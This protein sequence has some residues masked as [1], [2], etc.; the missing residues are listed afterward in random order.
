M[1]ILVP[2]WSPAGP[3]LNLDYLFFSKPMGPSHITKRKK[4]GKKIMIKHVSIEPIF[5]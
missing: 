2:G 5:A 3:W 4:V 1:A